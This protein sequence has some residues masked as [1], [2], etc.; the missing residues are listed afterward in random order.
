MKG[1]A[2]ILSSGTTDRTGQLHLLAA[3]DDEANRCAN[4]QDLHHL[5]DQVTRELGFHFFALLHHRSLLSRSHGLIRLDNYPAGW[6]E[7]LLAR[8][9]VAVD[10]VHLACLKSNA[11]FA[12]NELGGMVPLSATQ[13]HILERS[14]HYGLGPGFTVPAHVPGEASGSCSFAVRRGRTL[15]AH[16]LACAELVGLH[17]FKI[18][19]RLHD[20]PGMGRRPR[21]S[22][23]EHQCLRLLAAGK[24]DWEIAMIL[25]L[26]VE[27]VHQYVKRARAAYGVVSRTQLVV[28]GLRDSLVS[29]D[30]AIPAAGESSNGTRA[31][32]PEPS[33]SWR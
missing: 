4:V 30:E 18:A 25:G 5:L 11:G 14:G 28:C 2:P 9:D 10:P 3:F 19:R 29:F 17:A 26:S 32:L 24:T 20:F 7:E 6:E 33:N 31:V 21:L 27:T 16:R 12:W 15:P 1:H 8:H 13:R 22:P 23:R